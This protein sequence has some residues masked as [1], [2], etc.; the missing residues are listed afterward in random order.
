MTVEDGGDSREEL[1]LAQC[2]ALVPNGFIAP[3]ARRM[4]SWTCMMRMRTANIT[5]LSVRASAKWQKTGPK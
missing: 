4:K 5:C 1:E 2:S 3:I